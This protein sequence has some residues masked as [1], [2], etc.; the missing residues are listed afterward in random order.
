MPNNFKKTL[1][2]RNTAQRRE[3]DRVYSEDKNNIQKIDRPKQKQMNESLLK[4]GVWILLVIVLVFIY[5]FWFRP[6]GGGD[7]LS[8]KNWY[9]ATLANEEI[10]YGQI[11]NLKADPVVI[12]NVYYNYDQTETGS[13]NLRLVKRGKETY[14]PNGTMNIV[15]SQILYMEQLKENSKVLEA[16]FTYEQ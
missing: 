14:G 12:S 4:R 5:F 15:R 6:D 16:I 1:N 13:G 7:K 8:A 11:N 2:L 3:V 9:A 10:F